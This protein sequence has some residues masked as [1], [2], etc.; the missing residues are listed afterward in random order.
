V[1]IRISF[2]IREFS[3]GGR[4]FLAAGVLL[5]SLSAAAPARPAEEVAAMESEVNGPW[6]WLLDRRERVSRGV[7]GLGRNLDDWLAGEGVG[8]QINETYLS[9]RLNQQYGLYGKYNSKFKIGGRLDLPRV[10]DRW[11]LIFESDVEDLNTLEEN[12]LNQ[13]NSSD[14]VGAFRYQ[15]ETDSGWR[16]SHDIGIRSLA[17]TDPFYRF[18]ARYN[19]PLNEVWSVGLDQKFFYYD[20]RGWGT[21]TGVTFVR[22]LGP[23]RFLAIESQAYFQDNR[24]QIELAQTVTLHRTLGPEET[25][26]YELGVLGLNKPNIRVN[27][28]YA[29]VFYRRSIYEDWLFLEV[30]PQLLVSRDEDWRPEPRLIVN[31]EMLFFDF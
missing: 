7:T 25:V 28:Y 5:F 15:E 14:S 3:S 1:A 13:V 10:S 27:D 22:E 6:A 31:L 4:G 24:D 23:D 16:L 8:E 29:Q 11:K 30:A 9:V 12:V 26:S 2:P 17:P 18:R 21:D 20:T 19:L